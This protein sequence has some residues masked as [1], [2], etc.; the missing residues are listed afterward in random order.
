MAET[1]APRDTALQH[2]PWGAYAPRPLPLFLELVRHVA[3]DNAAL[4][5]RALDG[6]ARYERAERPP[7]RTPRPAIGD[8]AGVALRDHGGE[9]SPVILIPSLINPPHVLDLPG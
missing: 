1:V 7:P 5:K 4:A 6:L 8:V 2:G 9:G 3:S